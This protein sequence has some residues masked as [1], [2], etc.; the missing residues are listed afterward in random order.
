VKKECND[1]KRYKF[2]L[3]KNPLFSPVAEYYK[4][5]G[6]PT[7]FGENC[8]RKLK[9]ESHIHYNLPLCFPIFNP[10]ITIKMQR[11]NGKEQYGRQ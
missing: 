5:S 2:M 1:E 4:Y 7:S 9:R 10:S 8:T 11:G 3:L 6:L